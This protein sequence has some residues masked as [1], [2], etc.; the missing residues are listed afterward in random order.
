M[1]V[2]I[3]EEFLLFAATISS[4]FFSRAPNENSR[5]ENEDATDYDLER[6]AQ[7]R[8]IHV[9][10]ADEADHRE[11]DGHNSDRDPG[12]EAKLFNQIWQRVADAPRR[13]HE[14]AH[15]TPHPR[16]PAAGERPIIGE[17]FGKPHRNS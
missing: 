10:M 3:P 5:Q 9:S 4:S 1:L 17:G 6:G 13:C 2:G 7:Y 11:L 15:S 16:E 14:A 12:S 8:S